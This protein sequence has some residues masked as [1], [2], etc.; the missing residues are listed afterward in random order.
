MP[1]V[2]QDINTIFDGVTETQH[3]DMNTLLHKI[4]DGSVIGTSGTPSSTDWADIAL[5]RNGEF[6]DSS[7]STNR[8]TNLPTPGVGTTSSYKFTHIGAGTDEGVIL[9]R[10]SNLYFA[11]L[12]ELDSSHEVNVLAKVGDSYTKS[13]SDALYEPIGGGGGGANCKEYTVRLYQDG[14]ATNPSVQNTYVDE[15]QIDPTNNANPLYRKV[16][17][18]YISSGH[19]RVRIYWITSSASAVTLTKTALS[20]NDNQCK[21][22]GSATGTVG[23]FTYLEFTFDAT[24]GFNWVN[25]TLKLYN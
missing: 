23:G 15:L 13:E 11:K 8:P 19:Y 5:Y 25:M 9:Q 12:A 24:D 7:L 1:T 18:E 4:D 17:P 6:F 2:S 3:S 21:V 10:G 14:G 20:F 22:V 16:T